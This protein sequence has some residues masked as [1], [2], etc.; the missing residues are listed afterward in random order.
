MGNPSY[1]QWQSNSSGGSFWEWYGKYAMF[2][3][4]LDRF[5][6]PT[7]YN[8]WN[9]YRE[10]SYYD[11]VGRDVYGSKRDRTLAQKNQKAKASKGRKKS[12]SAMKN[13]QYRSVYA[14]GSGK[15]ASQ[16]KS[17]M[18]RSSGQRMKNKTA[19]SRFGSHQFSSFRSSSRGSSA[20]SRG[21]FRGK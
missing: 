4:V 6:G 9:R 13:R 8:T 19:S 21:V 11:S 7:R 3:H 18:R 2:S 15:S 1:G 16:S 14:S 17:A 10:P 12:F 5:S 20:A